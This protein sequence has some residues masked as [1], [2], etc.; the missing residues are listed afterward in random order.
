MPESLSCSFVCAL[1]LFNVQADSISDGVVLF[2]RVPFL[3]FEFRV[4]PQLAVSDVRICKKIGPLTCAGRLVGD[5][6]CCSLV[7]ISAVSQR[8]LKRTLGV[9]IIKIEMS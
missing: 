2:A 6:T 3:T 1:L 7:S 5:S 4:P 9:F 8:G